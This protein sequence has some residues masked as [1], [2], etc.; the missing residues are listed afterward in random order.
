LDL[1]GPYIPDGKI[2]GLEYNAGDER[3]LHKRVSPFGGTEK[4]WAW[5]LGDLYQTKW[6]HQDFVL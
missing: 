6:L 3:I 5:D 2:K 1:W 4:A